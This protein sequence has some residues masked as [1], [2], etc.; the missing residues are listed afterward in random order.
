MT[1]WIAHPQLI[2]PER[3]QR[4]LDADHRWRAWVQ[5]FWTSLAAGISV[6]ALNSGSVYLALHGYGKWSV[7]PFALTALPVVWL[8][9][10]A[11]FHP[12]PLPRNPEA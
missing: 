2:L 7:L 5:R 4:Q 10:K 11:V 9:D 12:T 1:L 6:F 3:L 8:I